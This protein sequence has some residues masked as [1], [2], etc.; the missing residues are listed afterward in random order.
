MYG[1]LK[2]KQIK[3]PYY[4]GDKEM[5]GGNK[6]PQLQGLKNTLNGENTPFGGKLTKISTD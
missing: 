1:V 4:L 2:S 3:K 5:I 6:Y